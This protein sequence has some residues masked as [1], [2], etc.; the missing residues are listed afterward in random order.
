MSKIKRKNK[1]LMNLTMKKRRRSKHSQTKNMAEIKK[2]FRN[3]N[4]KKK[5]ILKKTIRFK[6]RNLKWWKSYKIAKQMYHPKVMNTAAVKN[7]RTIMILKK[8]HPLKIMRLLNKNFQKSRK[9]SKNQ[10]LKLSSK[11]WKQH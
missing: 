1:S 10:T 2:L 3:L 4:L 11:I 7:K 8:N 6:I 5:M 9:I